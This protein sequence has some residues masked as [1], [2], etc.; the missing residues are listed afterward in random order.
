M[1]S[2]E[3]KRNEAMKQYIKPCLEYV[4]HGRLMDSTLPVNSNSDDIIT[5]S[6]EIL[7]K[8]GNDSTILLD[9]DD[10]ASVNVWETWKE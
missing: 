3:R 2:V 4:T 6:D 5:S 10:I 9:D 8:P 7:A 1:S